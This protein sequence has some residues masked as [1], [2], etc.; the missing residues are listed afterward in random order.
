[1]AAQKHARI[2]WQKLFAFLNIYL[3]KTQLI[4]ALNSL[5]SSRPYKR[6]LENPKT[7]GSRDLFLPENDFN[8]FLHSKFKK[9]STF[10]GPGNQ[11]TS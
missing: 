2:C 4:K 3:Y 9:T 11:W 7:G 10:W 8:T 6:L 5:D 1:M